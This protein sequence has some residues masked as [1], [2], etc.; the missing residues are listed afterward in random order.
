LEHLADDEEPHVVETT[1]YFGGLFTKE[2]RCIVEALTRQTLQL[3]PS[4]ETKSFF[5]RALTTESIVNDNPSRELH[6]IYADVNLCISAVKD[7][8]HQTYEVFTKNEAWL[9]R[10]KTFERKLAYTTALFVGFFARFLP[11][12][13][14]RKSVQMEVDPILNEIYADSAHLRVL[15]LGDTSNEDDEAWESAQDPFVHLSADERQRLIKAMSV[16]QIE[17]AGIQGKSKYRRNRW[18]LNLFKR[19]KTF[20]KQP[21]EKKR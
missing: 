5:G 3:H 17:R 6:I 8:Q 1:R 4:S 15:K 16:G 7:N 10:R 20:F 9:D 14:S 19:R 2:R 11:W 21:G 18:K 13:N 12:W